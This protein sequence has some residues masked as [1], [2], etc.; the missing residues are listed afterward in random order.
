MREP[1][2]Q[3]SVLRRRSALRAGCTRTKH[4]YQSGNRSSK[5]NETRMVFGSLQIE[6]GSGKGRIEQEVG[7]IIDLLMKRERLRGNRQAR[8]SGNKFVKVVLQGHTARMRP[9]HQAFFYFRV[10]A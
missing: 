6:I 8:L 3:A 5:L 4:S 2:S 1:S 9:R 7:K 10:K